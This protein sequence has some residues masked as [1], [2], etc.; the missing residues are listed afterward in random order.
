MLTQKKDPNWGPPH[1]GLEHCPDFDE[2][3]TLKDGKTKAVKYP[4]VGYNCSSDYQLNQKKDI[5]SDIAGLQHCPDFDERFTL[6]DGK[7][8]AVPYPQTG[9]NCNPEYAAAQKNSKK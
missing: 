4:E 1:G 3:F 7:T 5:G 8:R 2:R 6:V 9:Y